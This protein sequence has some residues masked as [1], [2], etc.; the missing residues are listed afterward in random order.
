[1]PLFFF[2]LYDDAVSVDE[3]GQ[4][5]TS[6]AAARERGV[7]SAREMACAEVRN[8]HLFLGHRIEVE[9]EAGATIATVHFRDVVTIEP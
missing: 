1:M 6:D 8:G 7:E 2:H 4:Q 3:E 9:N 5:L